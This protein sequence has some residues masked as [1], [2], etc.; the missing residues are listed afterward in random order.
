[1]AASCLIF[2]LL[3]L[4]SFTQDAAAQ[5]PAEPVLITA[6]VLLPETTCAYVSIRN[7]TQ[8]REAWLQTELGKLQQTPDMEAFF[9]DLNVQMK[10]RFST[11]R[12]RLGVSLQEIAEIADGEIAASVMLLSAETYSVAVII[13]VGENMIEAQNVMA[14][15]AERVK[16]SGGSQTRQEIQGA[17]VFIL[18][19][20]DQKTREFHK[21]Y[22]LLK[23]RLLLASDNM[24]TIMQM[25]KRL[26]LIQTNSEESLPCFAYIDGYTNILDNCF[27]EE[28][29]PDLV[30]YVDPIRYLLVQRIMELETNPESAKKTSTAEMLNNCGFQGVQA[31][32]GVFTLKSCGYD[33]THRSFVCIP[34]TPT[35]SLKMFK[36]IDSDKFVLPRW[37][38]ADVSAV[39]IVNMDF[40]TMID[41]VG[42]LFNQFFG[43]GDS[44]I[45]DDVLAGLKEDEFG[46][47]V[48]LRNDLIANFHNTFIFVTHNLDPKAT[49]QE[50]KLIAI[51]LRN[52]KAVYVALA[53]ILG[54]EPGFE[55]VQTPRGEV[56]WKAIPDEEIDPKEQAGKM[57]PEMTLTVWKGY[58]L[59]ASHFDYFDTIKSFDPEKDTALVKLPEF[60]KIF[61]E[62]KIFADGA[63]RASFHFINNVRM[64]EHFYQMCKQNSVDESTSANTSFVG[65]ILTQSKT[66]NQEK[67]DASALPD[68]EL[69][70]Q[71]FLPAGGMIINKPKGFLYQSFWMSKEKMGEP[72][73]TPQ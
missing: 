40:L 60:A 9:K 50:R 8:F 14:K 59:I 57:F 62:T 26:E 24:E 65:K 30:W 41:N 3:F 52:A 49:D 36:F 19:I 66:Q 2:S 17:K 64:R 10:D 12:D 18:N 31:V 63:P 23:D 70:K 56:Y 47:Q 33:A 6:D 11:I 55:V 32:G 61:K 7:F 22:Y 45:W 1:M 13:D 42:P 58:L 5:E 37:L 69:V 34:A 43:E 39:H 53:K 38:P 67:L 72:A 35:Q 16:A 27:V 71:Y 54:E 48:D 20:Q 29:L 46:P 68:F 15:V 28:K 25:L 44:G 73:S 21:A 51:P 4:G